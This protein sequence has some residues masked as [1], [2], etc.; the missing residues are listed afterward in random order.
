MVI[1]TA[2]QNLANLNE[3]K[4]NLIVQFANLAGKS[5]IE[6]YD[7]E[8]RGLYGLTGLRLLR[9]SNV[10]EHYVHTLEHRLEYLRHKT[11]SD[12]HSYSSLRH[13]IIITIII[14]SYEVFNDSIKYLMTQ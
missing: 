12:N 6:C 13:T 8:M 4:M 1:F 7:Y 14:N 3:V 5:Y 2:R 11:L 9:I 10:E